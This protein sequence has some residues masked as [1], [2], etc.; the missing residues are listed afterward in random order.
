MILFS[1]SFLL[2]IVPYFLQNLPILNANLK[3]IVLASFKFFFNIL[4]GNLSKDKDALHHLE[5]K[6][7]WY[8]SI[9]QY[10]LV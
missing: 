8:K 4:I 9:Y 2:D 7:S 5:K 1:F 3:H 6:S 10:I